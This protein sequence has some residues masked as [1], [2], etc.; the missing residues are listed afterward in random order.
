MS[1]EI[2]LKKK[3][4][5]VQNLSDDDSTISKVRLEISG[6]DENGDERTFI[7]IGNEK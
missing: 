6:V 5:K 2:K 1:K 3:R 4:F 7:F